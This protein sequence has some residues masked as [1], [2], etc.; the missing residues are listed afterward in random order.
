MSEVL[1][2]PDLQA[3]EG[4]VKSDEVVVPQVAA[5]EQGES[6]QWYTGTVESAIANA[7]LVRTRDSQR[8]IWIVVNGLTDLPLKQNPHKK[9]D[10]NVPD[11]IRDVPRTLDD[12]GEKRTVEFAIQKKYLGVLDSAQSEN[13][14]RV[15]AAL[16]R[17]QDPSDVELAIPV[18]HAAKYANHRSQFFQKA[19]LEQAGF[20]QADMIAHGF[21][22]D[23][24]MSTLDLDSDE[25]PHVLRVN[26]SDA[27]VS[28]VRSNDNQK[29]QKLGTAISAE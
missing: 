17:G 27:P 18:V 21:N 23:G 6:E 5:D 4:E 7:L 15:F 3:A 12:N 11:T 22:G 20:T 13:A 9:Y 19:T 24:E 25:L 8:D 16:E 28:G 2:E 1:K 10:P 29:D 26:P 14:R